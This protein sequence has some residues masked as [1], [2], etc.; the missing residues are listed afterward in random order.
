MWRPEET[1]GNGVSNR[2]YNS[3]SIGG[4]WGRRELSKQT[5]R[6]FKPYKVIPTGVITACRQGGSEVEES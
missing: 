2:S 1:A 3:L 6:L 5:M 4:Q